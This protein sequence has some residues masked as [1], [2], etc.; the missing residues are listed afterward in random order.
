MWL[1]TSRLRLPWR[2]CRLRNANKLPGDS[3]MVSPSVASKGTLGRWPGLASTQHQ[4]SGKP[5]GPQATVSTPETRGDAPVLGASGLGQVAHTWEGAARP[6]GSAAACPEPSLLSFP[7]RR[8]G[9]GPDPDPDP[10]PPASGSGIEH[11]H[12]LRPEL[13]GAAEKG[14]VSSRGE[15]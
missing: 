6:R 11:T 3:H 15:K 7:G 9:P 10:D 4:A 2:K 14:P 13:G 8:P 5:L 12:S 1:R